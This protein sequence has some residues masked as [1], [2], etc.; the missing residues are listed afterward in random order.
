MAFKSYHNIN[1]ATDGTTVTLIRQGESAGNLKSIVIVSAD[2]AANSCALFLRN[3]TE[4]VPYYILGK[5][6]L[7]AGATLLLDSDDMLAFNNS[8]SGYSLYL[9]MYDAT[10]KLNVLLK[11]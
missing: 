6:S 7:P 10:T 8:S 9:Q 4:L 3:D 2:I 11:K 5:T 1:S